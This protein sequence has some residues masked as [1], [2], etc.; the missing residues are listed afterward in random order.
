MH[1]GAMKAA[2]TYPPDVELTGLGAGSSKGF[3]GTKNKAIIS[4]VGDMQKT[5]DKLMFALI[6]IKFPGQY[7][8]DL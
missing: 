8:E 3:A 5:S 2:L 4:E 6:S 7:D 1:S